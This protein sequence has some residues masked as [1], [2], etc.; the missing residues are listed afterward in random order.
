MTAGAEAAN[1]AFVFNFAELESDYSTAR[2][3]EVA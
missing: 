1:R 3:S 2:V